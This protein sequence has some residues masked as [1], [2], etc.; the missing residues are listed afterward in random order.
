[1]PTNEMTFKIGGEAGQG[2]ESGGAGFASALASGGLHVF[3][4]Q[5]YMSRVRGGHNFFQIRVS[6][7]P[8]HSHADPVHL[9]MALVP[10]TIERLHHEIVPGGGLIYDQ[11]FE[12]DEERLRD[13]G[14]HLF[15]LPLFEIAEEEG[16]QVM[17]NTA[18]FGAAVGVTGYDLDRILR[19]IRVNFAKKSQK[20]VDANLRVA[21][22]AHDLARERYA[23]RF[24]YKLRSI[25]APQRMLINGNQA[26]CLGALLGGCRFVSAYPMTPASSIL[27]WWAGHASKYNLVAKHAEDEIAAICMAIGVNHAGVRA[28]TATSGGGFSLMVEALGLAGMTETPVVIVESQRPGPA[29]GMPTRTAQGDLLFALHASQGEFPR[30]VLAPGPVEECFH[31]GWRAF[32]LAEQIQSPVIV[33]LD[34]YTSVSMRTIERSELYFEDVRVDRGALLSSEDLDQ[35]SGRY[36]RYELTQTGVSPRAVPGH[37]KGVFQACSDEHDPYGHFEDEDAENRVQMV[38]KRLRKLEVARAEMNA[39][40]FYGPREADLTFV[41]W[42][43]TAGPIR[44][45]V[46]RLNGDGARANALHFSDIWPF[47]ED[48]AQ[49][50]LESARRLVSVENNAT[51]QFAMLLRAHTGVQVSGQILR[52]DGRP[53]SPEYILDRLDR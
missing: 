37:P 9:L 29:T 34:N 21:E 19:V 45:V 20:V 53:L 3:G 40:S 43:S 8:L 46:D 1:M 44:E 31:A 2:V 39:P 11:A 30:V 52:Y 47:P 25:E 27:E 42:G 14:I 33:L 50:L 13:R 5:D 35:L 41:G 22:R 49:P 24:E 51:G 15:P 7:H 23:D 10:K 32:N 28:M 36:R 4:L 26:F 38:D 6:E 17:A 18:A 16:T 12:V 48:R